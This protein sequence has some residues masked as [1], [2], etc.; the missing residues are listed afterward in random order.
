[1]ANEVNID[2]NANVARF[3]KSV[4]RAT[5]SL[6]QFQ[7]RSNVV[8]DKV[9]SQF[10]KL[11]AGIGAIALGKKLVEINREADKLEAALKTATGSSEEAARELE[12]LTKFAAETPFAI[13]QSIDAFIRLKNL[14]LDPSIEAL[15]S[16]GNTA[17]AT[18]KDLTQFI[19]AVAQAT[20]GE[21]ERL[22]AFGIRAKREGENVRFIF[23]GVTTEIRNSAEDIEKY[24]RDL[25]DI[26]FGGAMEERAKT[27]DGALSNL[28]DSFTILARAIGKSGVNDILNDIAR[29]ISEI[30]GAIP[31]F[32]GEVK[33]FVKAFS[34]DSRKLNEDQ[35]AIVER[36]RL[37]TAEYNRVKKQ[38]DEGVFGEKLSQRFVALAAEISFLQ[39]KLNRMRNPQRLEQFILGPILDEE[40]P[41]AA[42]EPPS[43]EEDEEAAD[44]A[45]RRRREAERRRREAL[46]EAERAAREAARAQEDFVRSFQD[47]EDELDPVT[48]KTEEYLKNVELLD[49]AWSEGLISGERYDELMF[50]LAEGTEEVVEAAEDARDIW[51]DLGP[52]F[53]SAFEDA[54]VAGSD[55]RDVLKGIEQDIIRIVSRE[56]VSKPLSTFV[57]GLFQEDG[58]L[59]SIADIFRASGGPVLANRPYVV[60]EK[61]AELFVPNTSGTIVPA[62]ATR[63]MMGNT[64]VIVNGVTDAESFMRNRKQIIRAINRESRGAAL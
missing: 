3:E 18:G 5:A 13:G 55:L 52:V 24:L 56:L 58:A 63:G 50:S 2:F 31:G 28:G 62:N 19:E 42:E 60:G 1:M 4:D 35:D 45:E 32:V 39:N 59:S 41:P 21:F 30:A 22:K 34:T 46:R 12:K 10:K 48:A 54:L 11:F 53:S 44:E 17:A 43:P 9:N 49:R 23:R 47:L 20:V 64:T 16:Y 29:T 38:M 61:G 57:G 6:N 7:K 33:T 15:R 51:Q 26:E 27:L 25:G 40:P 14:G 36:I 37:L 8:A